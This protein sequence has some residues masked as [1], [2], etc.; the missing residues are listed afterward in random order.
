MD[1]EVG[2]GILVIYLW[3]DYTLVAVTW[4]KPTEIENIKPKL[5]C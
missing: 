1:F 2:A 3:H 4:I 5:R